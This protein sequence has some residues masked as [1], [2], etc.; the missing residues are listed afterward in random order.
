MDLQFSADD[1]AAARATVRTF[2]PPTP[3]YE[4]PLLQERLGV[5]VWVKHENHTPAGAFKVRGGM[6]YFEALARTQP[7]VEKPP[8]ITVST[9][10]DRRVGATEVPKNADGYCFETTSSSDR[11]SRPAGK[12]P[13]GDPGRKDLSAGTLR[14]NTPPSAPPAL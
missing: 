14:K 1:V 7:E 4:W 8:M 13:S 12:A 2:V 3:Q 6:T 10:M 9:P 11:G 5:R